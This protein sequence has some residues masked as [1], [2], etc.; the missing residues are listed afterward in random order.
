MCLSSS[1]F[2]LIRLSPELFV[3]PL[4]SA[5]DAAGISA[6]Y[7]LKVD[8]II[9]IIRYIINKNNNFIMCEI[10]LLQLEKVTCITTSI[11]QD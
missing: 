7:N 5:R 9:A 10:F 1:H 2:D 4:R 11:T 8:N 3:H 6:I